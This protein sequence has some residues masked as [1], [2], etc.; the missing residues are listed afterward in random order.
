MEGMVSIGMWFFQRKLGSVVTGWR[1]EFHPHINHVGFL[2]EKMLSFLSLVL[3]AGCFAYATYATLCM[4]HIP[5]LFFYDQ[6]SHRPASHW[7]WVDHTRVAVVFFVIRLLLGLHSIPSTRSHG[8]LLRHHRVIRLMLEE[9]VGWQLNFSA[10]K[11]GK[12]PNFDP[13]HQ[14]LGFQRILKRGK[15]LAAS[16]NMIQGQ[17]WGH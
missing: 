5:W 17:L 11:R 3:G 16:F 12:G 13:K 8:W 10:P 1:N 7:P 9:L 6:W 2:L 4:R 15:L 14:F